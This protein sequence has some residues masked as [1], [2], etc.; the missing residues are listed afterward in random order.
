[1]IEH[2]LLCYIVAHG[3]F[4]VLLFK[5]K[6]LSTLIYIGF[7]LLNLLWWKLFPPITLYFLL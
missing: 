4:D 6:K 3:Y 5:D 7:S 2:L 1:M